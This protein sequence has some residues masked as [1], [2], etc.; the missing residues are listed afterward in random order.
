VDLPRAALA[1]HRLTARETTEGD[2]RILEASHGGGRGPERVDRAVTRADPEDR[3]APGQLVDARDGAGG[4]YEVSCQ[5]VRHDGSHP[6][7]RRVEGGE[8]E[9]DVQLAEHRLRVGDTEPVESARLCLAA[10][11]TEPGEGLRQKDDAEA[12]SGHDWA[13]P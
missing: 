1:L 2:D 7:P 10:Q 11:L 9:G 5:R 13:R 3:A 12:G 6:D 4:D 8:R